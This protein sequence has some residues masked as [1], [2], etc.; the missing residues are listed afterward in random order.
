M[1]DSTAVLSRMREVRGIVE[2]WFAVLAAPLAWFLGLNAQYGFVQLACERSSMVTLHATSVATLAIALA[3]T[4]ASWRIWNR[5]G[6]EPGGEA[7]GTVPRSRFMASIGL[8]GGALFMIAIAAQWL[9][10]M[11]LH[12]C[13]GI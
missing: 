8:L 10:N 12:P 11:F 1:H 2:Q 13:M 3:G 4:W 5:L 7:G 6:R 9:T